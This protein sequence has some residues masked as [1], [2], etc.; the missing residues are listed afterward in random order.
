MKSPVAVIPARAGSKRIPRKNVQ[1]LDGVP[2][3]GH[4]IELCW[5]SGLFNRVVVSTD[6]KE[7]ADIA[8]QFNADVPFIRPAE[9]ADDHTT[10]AAVMRHAVTSLSSIDATT[11]V[12]C[13]YPTA[14]LLT[15]E[16]IKSGLEMLSQGHH[17]VLCAARF[18]INPLRGFVRA[19]SNSI[20]LL[21]PE[22]GELRTQDL[23]A[24]Y[25]DVGQFYWAYA[26]E[27][28]SGTSIVADG[29]GFVEVER[30]TLLDVD[31]PEDLRALESR[32]IKLKNN[33]RLSE[34]P[35]LS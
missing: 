8:R 26:S 32:W 33:S 9:L 25:H 19:S 10:T 12:C 11:P 31:E 29:A 21:Q 18:E 15:P 3:L 20:R 2:L 1:L 22:N 28:E 23:P 24:V 30:G 27:W 6:D 17:H 4:A 34:I 7:I 5:K 14:V 16:L 35:T 13:I